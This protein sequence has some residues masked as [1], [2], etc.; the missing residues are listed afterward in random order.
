MS[1]M[2]DGY[3]DVDHFTKKK[4]TRDQPL[5]GQFLYLGAEV[6][7]DSQDRDW[8]EGDLGDR[9]EA[10]GG[11]ELFHATTDG[12]LSCGAEFVS[13]PLTINAWMD[14]KKRIETLFDILTEAGLRAHCTSTA[15]LHVHM[16]A[17]CFTPYSK[18]ALVYLIERNWPQ[19]VGFARRSESRYAKRSLSLSESFYGN[20]EK[21]MKDAAKNIAVTEVRRP[22]DRYR[23]VNF[24]PRETVEIR[25]FKGTLNPETFYATLQMCHNLAFVC[26]N[27]SVDDIEFFSITDI[28]DVIKWP[29]LDGY[30]ELHKA[31]IITN[32]IS[33]QA[34]STTREE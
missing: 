19:F 9:W 6:E 32:K 25:M 30:I 10:A 15:G 2:I 23:A 3:H 11:Y 24:T 14:E 8:N 20:P 22:G 4:T 28:A 18:A 5:N 31:K 34:S 13:N 7:T 17:N 33:Y 16:S 27:M 12:S 29:E 1:I 26:N 21:E